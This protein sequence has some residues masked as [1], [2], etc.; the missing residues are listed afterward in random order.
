L[1][2][3]LAESGLPAR[4]AASP[5]PAGYDIVSAATLA[6][7]PLLHGAAISPGTHVDLVGAFRPTMREADAALLARARLVVD[8]RTGALAEAGDVVQ[9]I[10]EGAITADHIAADLAQLCRG[11]APGRTD[12]AEVTLFKSVGWAGEDLAAAALAYEAARAGG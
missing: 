3:R 6:T 5:D 9:A 11:E 8:T 12:A 7:T 2:A 4:A 1:A 10:A